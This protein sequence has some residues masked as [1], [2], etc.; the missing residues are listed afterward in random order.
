MEE[1]PRHLSDSAGRSISRDTDRKSWTG[2]DRIHPIHPREKM[3]IHILI[4]KRDIGYVLLE[5]PL[6][7]E[8]GHE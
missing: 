2:L 5:F 7:C 3:H 8:L 4:C 1:K 6:G